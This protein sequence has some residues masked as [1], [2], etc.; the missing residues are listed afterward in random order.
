[1]HAGTYL[2]APMALPIGASEIVTSGSGASFRLN[3]LDYGFGVTTKFTVT[4]GAIGTFQGQDDHV[5]GRTALT[6][7]TFSGNVLTSALSAVLA[8]G[9]GA[10]TT[11][12]LSFGA[13]YFDQV[14]LVSVPVGA[15]RYLFAAA[16][17][18]AG[19]SVFLAS[20]V[21]GLSHVSDIS[22]TTAS[23]ADGITAMATVQ[24]GAKSF[25]YVGSAT[26]DGITGYEVGAGGTITEVES[27]GTDQLI[28]T[29]DVTDMAVA[30]VGGV[31]YL[32]VAAAESSSLTVFAVDPDGTLTPVDHVV[33]DLGTRFQS[34]SVMD[35]ITTG[36]RTY[37]VVAGAD[38]G[39][40]LLT[41]LP[42]GQLLHV[43]TLSDT[44]AMSLAHASAIK[45]VPVGN[46]LQVFVTSGLEAGMTMFRFDLSNEGATLIGGDTV[47][48]L[49]GTAKD[50]ILVQLYG[51]ATLSGGAGADILRDGIDSDHLQ[52]GNGA[53]TF[54]LI[55]DGVDDV[56]MDF[57]WGKDRIDL[58]YW[59][60]LRN[61]DELI[62]T[63]TASGATIR[64]GQEF[65]TI[66]T[67]DGRSLLMQDFTTWGL[68]N[69]TRF[70]VA[71]GVPQKV[72]QGTVL[73]ETLMG[74][75]EDELFVGLEGDDVFVSGGGHD[76]FDGGA[77]FDT[78]DYT[79]TRTALTIDWQFPS[80]T[81]GPTPRYSSI[82]GVIGSLANDVIRLDSAANLIDGGTGD[83]L[84]DG[85]GGQ[86]TIIGG[87]GDDSLDG[88]SG[89]DWA[90]YDRDVFAGGVFGVSVDLGAGT[91]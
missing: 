76:L 16:A 81:G 38:D 46:E 41:L 61:V 39:L 50:D 51:D 85:R 86:D 82:E 91:A 43:Q 18:G 71:I 55:E 83:D 52:G 45:I 17:D 11:A 89:F 63:P 59:S 31:T 73:G 21:G 79:G 14:E 69:I 67:S 40:T 26:E 24:M 66:L 77:G 49:T 28:P 78:V 3:V 2:G 42:G 70:P 23:Y 56:I 32:I 6:A 88:G 20:N 19:F 80:N 48:T 65:L 29:E 62:I 58:S 53:D 13:D 25:V 87:R 15:E 7:G 36:G 37:V 60:Y 34:V 10:S 1:M 33:D 47:G 54:V 27:L 30:S 64:Y 74:T 35:V 8:D 9:P 22:D 72:H 90:Y 44:A 68:L 84:L 75:A 12:F 57:E 4:A 5:T